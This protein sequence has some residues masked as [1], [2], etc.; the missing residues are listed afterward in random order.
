M[1]LLSGSGSSNSP[2]WE[3]MGKDPHTLERTIM[4][5][6]IRVSDYTLTLAQEIFLLPSKDHDM[7]SNLNVTIRQMH[8]R[9]MVKHQ[10]D[11]WKKSNTGRQKRAEFF[12][13]RN[14]AMGIFGRQDAHIQQQRRGQVGPATPSPNVIS[15]TQGGWNQGYARIRQAGFNVQEP[16]WGSPSEPSQRHD[17]RPDSRER[18]RRPSSEGA[19][20]AREHARRLYETL[21]EWAKRAHDGRNI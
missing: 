8:G 12:R 14:K 1:K 4:D 2:Q 13:E 11:A 20:D 7:H 16:S 21:P 6:E 10:R 9:S 5:Y 15:V 19:V 3:N 17:Q 18:S